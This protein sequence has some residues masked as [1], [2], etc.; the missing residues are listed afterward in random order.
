LKSF[1]DVMLMSYVLDAGR[2]GHGLEE[3]SRR[4]LGHTMLDMADIV[5][6]GRTLAPFETVEVTRAYGICAET[7]DVSLRVWRLLSARLVA[8]RVVTVYQTLE[9]PLVPVLA[10]MEQRGISID[11][12]VLSRLSG[13]FAQKA[14]ALEAEIQDIAGEPLNPGSPKQIADILFGKMKLP[15]AR[16][17]KTATWCTSAW[18]VGDRA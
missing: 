14:A 15:R 2:S 16:K 13:D 18:V 9:R 10:R 4:H 11:S 6:K 12:E 5:G 17:T 7:A 8:E 1:D 3:L